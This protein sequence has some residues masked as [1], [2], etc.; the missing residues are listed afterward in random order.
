[1]PA[2]APLQPQAAQGAQLSR[3][4]G[5]PQSDVDAQIMAMLSPASGKDAVL[6]PTQGAQPSQDVITT[7]QGSRVAMVPLGE[8]GVLYTT[9]R[10][11]AVEAMLAAQGGRVNDDLIGRLLFNIPGGKPVDATHVTTAQDAAGNDLANIVTGPSN[12][13]AAQAAAQDIA[14]TTGGGPTVAGV[15]AGVAS[16]FACAMASA[17][18]RARS[19]AAP[20]I[21]P[22]ASASD[23][24]WGAARV[25]STAYGVLSSPRT[26]T[27]P[28]GDTTRTSGAA[29]EVPSEV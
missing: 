28:S 3:P 24:S 15:G 27:R 29:S 7:L 25:T 22:S 23:A 11:K 20:A 5:E 26:A 4:V 12:Q 18:R 2:A 9:N 17:A 16:A 8:A 6:V 10:T 14:G 21:A 1:M 19:C 13:A